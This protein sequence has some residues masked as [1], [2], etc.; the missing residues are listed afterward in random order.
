MTHPIAEKLK[1]AHAAGRKL[2]VRGAGHWS[3]AGQPVR[4]D[5]TLSLAESRGIV[6]YVPGDL[7]MTLRAG[8]TFEEIAMA[9][10]RE[11]QWLPLDPWGG[12]AGT[13]GATISTATSGPFSLAMGLPRD[14]V[15]GMEFVTGDGQVVRS[16]GRVVK[17][18]AGFDLTRLLVGSWGTLGVIT[19]LTVRLRARPEV[20]ETIAVS[21]A[22]TRTGLNDLAARLRALPFTPLASELVNTQLAEHLGFGAQ[23]LL[24]VALG[25][26]PRA[27]K[28]QR[29]MVREFGDCVMVDEGVWNALRSAEHDP[30]GSWRW[31]Q[32][33]S[34]FGDTWTAADT[35][36]RVLE[37][38]H[39]HGNPARGV[40]RVVTNAADVAASPLVRAAT[41][42]KGT[43]NVES[44]PPDAWPLMSPAAPSALS[45]GIRDKFDPAQILNDGILG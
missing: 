15:L 40:V 26:N 31:S 20:R 24:L 16:G 45:R 6:E 39:L 35:S 5:E 32:L 37:S 8:T 18:V 43:V 7:T 12:D 10:S 44:L 1:W 17:N 41:A 22:P 27:V 28:G 33:P 30:T 9:S 4:A 19:E 34:Q 14:L 13:I 2:R 23:T 25:G 42:F 29:A 11:G 21:V 36:A 3:R 38:F